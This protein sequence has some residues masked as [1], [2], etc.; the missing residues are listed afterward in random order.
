MSY[1]I[2]LYILNS[3]IYDGGD[4]VG[5]KDFGFQVL[6]LYFVFEILFSDEV[7]VLSVFLVFFF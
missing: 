7:G 5:Q 6:G 1:G 4:N 3:I 2:V